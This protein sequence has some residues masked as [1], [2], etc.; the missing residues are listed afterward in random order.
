MIDQI[1]H[2]TKQNKELLFFLTKNNEDEL[3]KFFREYWDG[4]ERQIFS[5]SRYR[6]YLLERDPLTFNDFQ[7]IYNRN[8][9]K[10]L[11][12]LFKHVVVQ[13]DVDEVENLLQQG[14][15]LQDIFDVHI[16]DRRLH[17]IR[18]IKISLVRARNKNE[19][20]L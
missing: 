7:N 16:E 19:I 11:E 6:M 3:K 13:S 9:K 4:P 1:N 15:T 20:K 17:L 14:I 5:I 8:K 12:R 18:V 2:L 10:A